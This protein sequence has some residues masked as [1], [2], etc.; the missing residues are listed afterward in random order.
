MKL[1][2]RLLAAIFIGMLSFPATLLAQT[3]PED[4]PAVTDAF[5][6]SFLKH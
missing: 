2:N 3:E 5:Q 6:D 4:I 1:K